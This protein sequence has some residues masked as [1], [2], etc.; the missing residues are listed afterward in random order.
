MHKYKLSQAKM[1][2]PPIGPYLILSHLEAWDKE[3]TRPSI[4]SKCTGYESKVSSF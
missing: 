3:V 2:S 4:I 1:T